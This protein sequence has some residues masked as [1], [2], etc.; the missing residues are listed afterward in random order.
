VLRRP[1]R[2]PYQAGAHDVLREYRVLRALAGSAVPTPV[3]VSAC[4]GDSEGAPFYLMERVHG[5]V[6]RDELPAELEGPGARMQA[7]AALVDTLAEIHA[8]DW[9]ERGLRARDDGAGY[10]E[11]QIRTWTGQLHSNGAR[12]IP[13]LVEAGEIL[14]A[15]LPRSGPATLVHGDYKID[16]VM[17]APAL[18]PV[19]VAVLDWEMATV[20]DPLADVGFLAAT[21]VDPGEDADR[22]LGLS[23]V[24]AQ[25]GFPG[26]AWLLERYAA[27]TGRDLEH[28]DWYQGLALW[29]LA[30]LLESSYRRYLA[31]TTDDPFF[32]RLEAGVPALGRQVLR[33]VA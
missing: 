22:V 25:D 1:P 21:W 4:E 8:V 2:P 23:R 31:G 3:P 33:L 19:I 29:K 20:G 27:V 9:R 10:L 5:H 18:P 14:S 12:A 24:T 7:A 30:V 32:A 11:R 26:R 28:I 13:E 6:L 16:N 17:F 15:R